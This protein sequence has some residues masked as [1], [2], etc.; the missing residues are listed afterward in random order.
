MVDAANNPAKSLIEWAGDSRATLAIVFT[1]IVGSTA[2]GNALGDT[3]MGEVRRAHFERSAAL[4]SKNAGH[5][6][7]TIGDSVM[8]VFRSAASAFD[9]AYALHLD[10]GHAALQRSGV[11]AGIHIGSV[12]VTA[13]DIFGSEVAFA[14]RVAHEIA[15][16]EIWLSTQALRDLRVQ[17]A[18][19]HENTR[20]R[21]HPN[22]ALKGFAG[23]HLLWSAAPPSG[24]GRTLAEIAATGQEIAGPIPPPQPAIISNIPAGL[25]PRHFLGR[26]KALVDIGT[27]LNRY[28]GRAAIVAA[29][30]GLR[31]VGKTVL[32]AAYAEFHQGDYRAAWWVR[33]Q[34]DSGLR[35]DL[36]ALGV[37]L[38]WVPADQ[39]EEIALSS[40]IDRLHR[41]G[42]AILLVYDNAI[43]A[44]TLKPYLPQG[45]AA[46]VIVTSNSPAWRDVAETVEI[47]VWPKEDGADYLTIRT[48][49][50]NERIAALALSEALGGLPLAHEQAAA[51]CERLGIG[52][53]EYHRRFQA[54]PAHLLDMARDAPAEYYDRRTVAKTFALAIEE[55][56]KR[57]PGAEPLIVY[58]AM[59]APEPIP[60]FLFS[61]AREKLGEPLA[62]NLAGDGL[63]DAVAALRSFALL[64]REPTVDERDPTIFTDTI[65]L[66]RLV[67]EVAALRGER[68]HQAARRELLDATSSTYPKDVEND[69]ASW[70]RA[71][72]LDPIALDLVG[73]SPALTEGNQRSI[74]SLLT[75][76]A[77]YRHHILAAY[78]QARPLYERALA[79]REKQL[80]PEHPDTAHSLNDLGCLLRDQ[81]DRAGARPLF[82][83]ALAINEKQLGPEHPDTASSLNNLA[84]LLQDQGDRAGARPLY[85]RALA[86]REK[87]LGPEHPDT[88]ASINNLA[89]LLRDQGNKVRARAML[90]RALAICL[91]QL[92]PRHP[93]TITVRRNLASI[94]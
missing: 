41:E 50:D 93:D 69:L 56:A 90:N 83:R 47:R 14:A 36:V 21:D 54:K 30:H 16:A 37:R 71:R 68:V 59:L 13:T 63:D 20:W 67:R 94:R 7:K 11:R 43:D 60:L 3:A 22:L 46:H 79:M 15:D 58:A 75:Q 80:G 61:E 45:G 9:Y 24:P 70:P 2:L 64:D 6:I 84:S 89:S 92:G 48:G 72:R 38:G 65:R 57:H 82:E 35:A 10:P 29:L 40:V 4:I 42:E 1:D 34:T 77:S 86:I 17:R 31:G 81:G 87:Q 73:D 49:R 74:S 8:A 53:A 62:S 32:A 27:A 5:E 76:L 25:V 23:T 85:E 66:H 44:P 55:A 39:R 33:A 26:D 52:L 88:A 91:K 18:T 78:G 12:E 19:H 51:Y 28:R